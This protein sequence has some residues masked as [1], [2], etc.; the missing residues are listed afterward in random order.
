MAAGDP[1][2]LG[3]VVDRDV[4][5]IVELDVFDGVEDVL[6]GRAAAGPAL[7]G[8]FHQ[9]GDEEVEVAHHRRLVL[10]PQPAG[11]VDVLKGFAHLVGALGVVDRLLVREGQH[12]GQT[13]GADAVEAHPAVLPRLLGV[14][15]VG[16]QLVGTDEKEVAGGE[17]P[18]FAAGLEGALARQDQVDEI[19]VPD[20]GAPGMAGGA[21]LQAAVKDRKVYV[22]GEILFEGLFVCFRH[23]GASSRADGRAVW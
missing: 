17:L 10:H 19:V 18:R 2:A 5:G 9:G 4:V 11:A 15:G 23:R 16:V 13:V 3:H 1:H 12:R 22:A 21:P 6:A 7:A 14:G 8:L 20:A